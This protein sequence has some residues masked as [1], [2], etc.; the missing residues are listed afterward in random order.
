M[1]PG[2][3]GEESIDDRERIRNIDPAPL[4]GPLLID[5]ENPPSEGAAYPF[6]PGFEH[7]C[8]GRIALSDRLDP[9]PDLTDDEDTR[10]G[11]F[12]GDG[13]DPAGHVRVAPRSFA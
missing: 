3:G 1:H 6:E 2:G 12:A 8:L 5:S 10:V 7:Q 13:C 9:P 4:L 11:R